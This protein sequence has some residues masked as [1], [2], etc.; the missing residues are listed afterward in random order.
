MDI[1]DRQKFEEIDA[2]INPVM[3]SSKRGRDEAEKIANALLYQ[4][5]ISCLDNSI[6]TPC[7]SLKEIL[8]INA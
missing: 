3:Q 6:C 5:P 2:V 7:L 1:K 4:S 8:P